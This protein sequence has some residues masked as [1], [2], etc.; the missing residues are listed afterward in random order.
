ML[1]KFIYQPSSKEN[2]LVIV[3]PNFKVNPPLLDGGPFTMS[4]NYSMVK[5]FAAIGQ[6]VYGSFQLYQTAAENIKYYGFDAYQLTIIPYIVMS[7]LNLVASLCEP[8]F[9]AIFLVDRA[10]EIGTDIRT[11][12]APGTSGVVG[13][14][15]RNSPTTARSIFS[16]RKEQ[17]CCPQYYRETSSLT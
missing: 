6:I 9:P 13:I 3:P 7:F 17:V 10:P 4:Y 5:A 14:I 8:Q 12:D 1:R 2:Y 16:I 15:P 11:A